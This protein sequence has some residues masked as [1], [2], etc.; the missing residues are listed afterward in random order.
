MRQKVRFTKNTWGRSFVLLGRMPPPPASAAVQEL[1][2][3][4]AGILVR[5]QPVL[6]RLV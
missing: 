6:L 4:Y 5:R 3:S 2:P 1:W